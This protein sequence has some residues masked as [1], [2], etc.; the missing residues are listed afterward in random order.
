MQ[1]VD[2]SV[3]IAS[4]VHADQGLRA[5]C[6]EHVDASPLAIAH[7]NSESYARITALPGHHRLAPT[8]ARQVLQDMF[9]EPPLTLSSPGCLRVTQLVASSGVPGGPDL[10]LRHCRG[11]S[12]AWCCTCLARPTRIQELCRGWS[13]LHP[14]VGRPTRSLATAE[15][16]P[17]HGRVMGK[18]RRGRS[19]A[20]RPRGVQA[21]DLSPPRSQDL[22]RSA[23]T[24]NQASHGRAATPEWPLAEGHPGSTEARP[25]QGRTNAPSGPRF[26]GPPLRRRPMY[27]PRWRSLSPWT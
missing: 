25:R 16:D 6:R 23:T 27:G 14:S 18:R 2:P 24:A 9:P 12:G 4:L 19:P 7:V 15:L 10:R 22:A 1:V 26:G 3:V 20:A 21:H 8:I 17:G 13:R 5:A 11:G